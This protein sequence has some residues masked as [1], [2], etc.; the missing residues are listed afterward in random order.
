[1]RPAAR[2]SLLHQTAMIHTIAELRNLY[3]APKGRAVT[4]QLDR[5]DNHCLRFIALSPFVVL[6]SGG[7][8]GAMDASPRGGEPGF[9]KVLDQRTLLI[10]DSPGN[11]RL[12][13]LENLIQTGRIGMLFM[14]PGVD[15]TLR[16]NGSARLVRGEAH[17]ELF[18][19]DK[20]RP[21]LVIEVAVAEA[22]LHCAKAFMRSSLWDASRHVNRSALPTTRQMLNDQTGSDAPAESQEAM[23]ARYAADL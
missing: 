18:S 7:A 9:I 12:D 19:S 5:L 22:Y 21:K 23:V 16:V 14:V 13:T 20:R 1:L 10:P 6:A 2:S 3:P 17:L 8:N 4:K 11:N 15:E